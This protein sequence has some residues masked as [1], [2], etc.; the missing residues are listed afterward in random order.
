MKAFLRFLSLFLFVALLLFV[1]VN[2]SNS[3]SIETSFF[4]LHVNVGFLILF[5]STLAS[6][7]T[8]LFL[9]A[10][11]LSGGKNEKLLKRQ[12]ED[13]KLS[14]EIESDKVKQ[15]EAK[16]KTLEE[17]LRIATKK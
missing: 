10:F 5:C 1:L 6:L 14:H 16:I 8:L 7:S 17:A 15:L 13:I 2:T 9:M 12:A 3:I 4:S 11:N